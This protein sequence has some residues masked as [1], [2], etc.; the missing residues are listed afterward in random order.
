MQLTINFLVMIILAI[1]IFGFGIKFATQI[2]GQGSELTETS[3][4][5]ADRAIADLA[6]QSAERV[7][8]PATTKTLEG[9][10]P[11]IFGVVIENVLPTTETF[12]V[13]VEAAP[14]QETTNLDWMPKEPRD[15]E[16]NS[17]EKH[18]VGIVVR[19][20]NAAVGTYTFVAHVEKGGELYAAA[21]LI[22]YVKVI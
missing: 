16:I 2:F 8:L 6:C 19:S 3:F 5:D 11:A 20:Q 22:F 17:K 21:P 18:N 7:C 15:V 4:E 13:R 9:D 14:G 10:D 1:T 12:S